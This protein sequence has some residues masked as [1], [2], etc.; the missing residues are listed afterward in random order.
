MPAAFGLGVRA[1]GQ[2]GEQPA[3]LAVAPASRLFIETS[4][5]VGGR[6]PGLLDRSVP[7][8]ASASIGQKAEAVEHRLGPRRG[9]QAAVLIDQSFVDRDAMHSDSRRPVEPPPREPGCVD[10]AIVLDR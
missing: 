5:D 3:Q 6:D 7:E 9:P 4:D 8:C 2:A 1:V 10:E